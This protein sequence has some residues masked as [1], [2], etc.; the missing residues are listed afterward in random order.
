MDRYIGTLI[1]IINP[2]TLSVYIPLGFGIY[3]DKIISLEGVSPDGDIGS[4]RE[5]FDTH[6]DDIVMYITNEDAFNVVV[7]T[8]KSNTPTLNE[9]LR[10]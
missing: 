2:N 3:L 6:G 4:V 7:G 8:A 10:K 5:W 1:G 9:Y